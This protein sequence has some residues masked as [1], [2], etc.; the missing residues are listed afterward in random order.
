M[1]ST[2]QSKYTVHFLSMCNTVL[3]VHLRTFYLI[4]S[5][6]FSK[7]FSFVEKVTGLYGKEKYYV[8]VSTAGVYSFKFI[9][10]RR[11]NPKYPLRQ[12]KMPIP[13]ADE[14][15]SPKSLP[16]SPSH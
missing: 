11:P 2:V 15:L 10:H 4:I 7:V 13:Q 5:L 12:A 9:R 8:E 1:Y 3:Y 6:I 16:Q 14:V